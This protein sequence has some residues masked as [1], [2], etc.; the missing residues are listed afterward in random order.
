MM[1]RRTT[2]RGIFAAVALAGA[3]MADPVAAACTSET[4]S[5]LYARARQAFE[6]KR[7]DES[8]TLLHIAYD[9]DPNP[10]YL[11]NIA[12]AY[13]EAGRQN[14]ALDAWRAYLNATTD[15][16][17]RAQI[18]ARIAILAR[19]IDDLDRLEREKR[20]AEERRA[21]EADRSTQPT[22]EPAAHR[23][24]VPVSTWAFA[25]VAVVG[26]GS[27]G[28]FWWKGVDRATDLRDSCAP[29]CSHDDVSSARTRFVIADV[30]LGVGIAA[31]VGAIVTYLASRSHGSRS[32]ASSVAQGRALGE[33]AK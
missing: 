10:V 14:D 22:P 5:T 16:R 7:Y 6:A 12:R 13:E 29:S 11:G 19:K 3:T 9:C 32:Q 1:P 21:A 30:A 8:V 4:A 25:G 20:A 33:V 28:W 23:R 2:A 17:E 18:E 27:F 31:G 26:F 15:E 24:R